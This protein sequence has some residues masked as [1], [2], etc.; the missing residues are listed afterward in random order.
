[1]NIWFGENNK[2]RICNPYTHPFI[3]EEYLYDDPYLGRSLR[4]VLKLDL[5]ASSQFRG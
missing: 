3:V 4:G 1:M 5:N 2:Y